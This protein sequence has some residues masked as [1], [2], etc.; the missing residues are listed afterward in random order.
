[1]ALLV[2]QEIALTIVQIKEFVIKDYVPVIK[3]FLE[4][5]VNINRLHVQTIVLTT[6]FAIF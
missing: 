5:F 4:L 3:A 1:V 2:K 6:D